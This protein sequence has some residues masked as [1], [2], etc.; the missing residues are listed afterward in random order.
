MGHIVLRGTGDI[1]EI[2]DIIIDG[3]SGLTSSFSQKI[4]REISTGEFMLLIFEKH[5]MRNNSRAT[6]TVLINRDSDELIIDAIGSGGGSGLILNFSFGANA[7]LAYRVQRILE[8]EGF[9]VL[10]ENGG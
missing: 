4:H 10:S 5:F 9:R 7:D 6:L 8:P 2:A 1:N 3:M